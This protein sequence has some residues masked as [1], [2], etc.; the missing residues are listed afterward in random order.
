MMLAVL[1]CDDDLQMC[2]NSG[3]IIGRDMTAWSCGGGW[4]LETN[5]GDTINIYFANQFKDK[6][7]SW[8]D[9]AVPIYV[10]YTLIDLPESNGC[11]DFTSDVACI[12]FI[13]EP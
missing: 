2:T 8:P 13:E 1:G 5:A 12:N 6:L 3:K 4:L 7:E 10:T 9:E 11:G